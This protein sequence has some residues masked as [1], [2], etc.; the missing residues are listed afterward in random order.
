MA[1]SNLNSE[2]IERVVAEVIRR[3][4]DRGVTVS[5]ESDATSRSDFRVSENVVAMASLDGKLNGVQRVVV[6]LRAIVTPAVKDELRDRGI[7]LVRST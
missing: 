2:L 1:S 7:E 5:S 6:G 3:L 4:L